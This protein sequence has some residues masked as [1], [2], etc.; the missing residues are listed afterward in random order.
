MILGRSIFTVSTLALILLQWLWHGWLQ[1]NLAFALMFSVPLLIPV[2]WLLKGSLR[3]AA[4]LFFLSLIHFLHGVTEAMVVPEFRALALLETALCLFMYASMVMW[5]A[6]RR[7][8]Q[9]PQ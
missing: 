6:A 8:R 2:P 3:A 9:K 5:T 4:S 7:S 1:P